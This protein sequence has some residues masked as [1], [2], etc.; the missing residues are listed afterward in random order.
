MDIQT[1]LTFAL[2]DLWA[3]RALG[4][5]AVIARHASGCWVTTR[6]AAESKRLPIICSADPEEW[7]REGNLDNYLDGE[8]FANMAIDVFG[9]ELRQ[10]YFARN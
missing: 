2:E 7:S 9:D 8:H 6:T 3:E 10:K 5:E 4:R 1:E